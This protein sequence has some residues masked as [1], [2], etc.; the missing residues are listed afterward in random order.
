MAARS[1]DHAATSGGLTFWQRTRIAVGQ[2][3]H[4]FSASSV[5]AATWPSALRRGMLVGVVVLVAFLTGH[6]AEGFGI[7]IGALNLGLAD[8]VVPRRSLAGV[9]AVVTVGTGVIAFLSS[10]AA[11]TWWSLL[12]LVVLA[13]VFGCVSGSGFAAMQASFV[14]LITAIVFSNDPGDAAQALNY[15]VCAM[16]GC[17]LQAVSGLI[18][19]RYE[20]H[21]SMRRS[22]GTLHQAIAAMARSAMPDDEIGYRAANR[23]IAAEQML[24]GGR[25]EP[26]SHDYY[27]AVIR[28]AHELRM[29][30]ATWFAL[31]QEDATRT[32]ERLEAIAG[33]LTVLDARLRSARRRSDP[34]P[35]IPRDDDPVWNTVLHRLDDLVVAVDAPVPPRTAGAPDT[36]VARRAETGERLADRIAPWL[37]MLVPGAPQ[38]WHGLRLA[39]A[40]G[41]AQTLA[42]ALHVDRGYWLSLTVLVCLQ[43]DFARTLTHGAQRAAG[44]LAGVLVIGLVTWVTDGY[45]LVLTLV[46]AVAA[47]LVMKFQTANYGIEAFFITLFVGGLLESTAPSATVLDFRLLNTLAGFA[48]S[49]LVYLILPRWKSDG[50]A[51]ELVKVIDTQRARMNEVLGSLRDPA[52]ADVARLRG[53]GLDARNAL[54]TARA[55]AEASAIEPRHIEKDPRAAIELLDACHAFGLATMAVEATVRDRGRTLTPVDAE[56]LRARLDRTMAGTVHAIEDDQLA[57]ADDPIELDRLPVTNDEACNRALQLMASSVATISLSAQRVR[58][59]LS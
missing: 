3:F 37:A 33:T 16:I 8:A 31:P 42:L 56:P 39:V 22:L 18:A 50:L 32:P 49:L 6:Q 7:A 20:R 38:W 1:A 4:T 58:G 10:L 36:S 55:D 17:V 51:A 12:L 29:A 57:A 48:I 11:G 46:V 44:T 35:V 2:A 53:L 40:I 27:A 13:Y 43:P 24:A 45:P 5:A 28:R 52:G 14:P 59:N 34:L 25:F 23:E 9:F 15:A 54:V 47:P 19:W 41:I 26:A 30:L 21:A